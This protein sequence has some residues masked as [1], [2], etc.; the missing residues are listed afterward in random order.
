VPADYELPGN[1]KTIGNQFRSFWCRTVLA[2]YRRTQVASDPRDQDPVYFT[3]VPKPPRDEKLARFFAKME[4]IQ[5]PS[6]PVADQAYDYV[7]NACTQTGIWRPR[8]TRSRSTG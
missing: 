1:N 7:V 6:F 3:G 2:V 8:P 5:C 4:V